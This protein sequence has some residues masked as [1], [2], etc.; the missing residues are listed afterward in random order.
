MENLAF[1]DDNSDAN[2]DHGQQEGDNTDCDLTFEAG[3]HFR[4]P[5]INL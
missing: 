3:F 2:K 5:F 1:S 4:I